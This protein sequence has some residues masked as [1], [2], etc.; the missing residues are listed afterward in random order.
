MRC[1]ASKGSH[2]SETND[3]P[4]TSA[5]GGVT[6]YQAA[7]RA[8][9]PDFSFRRQWAA[10]YADGRRTYSRRPD[11]L[12]RRLLSKLKSSRTCTRGLARSEVTSRESKPP[13]E[14]CVMRLRDAFGYAVVLGFIG[15]ATVPLGSAA[16]AA[17]SWLTGAGMPTAALGADGD[18]YL[19]IDTGRIFRKAA[20]TWQNVGLLRAGALGRGPGWYSGSGS[21]AATFGDEG[22]M[23]LDI[24]IGRAFKKT[25]GTWLFMAD[26]KGPQGPQG[27][28]GAPGP[29]G[30][31][32]PAGPA[33]AVS[34][35][36]ADSTI[37]TSVST[38]IGELRVPRTATYSVHAKAQLFYTGPEFSAARVECQLFVPGQ[39]VD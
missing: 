9:V 4:S 28:P 24:A 15:A 18:N 38:V 8:E 10:T 31:Q 33:P 20:G 3:R 29:P 17:D 23:Y 25:S 39:I 19:D 14:I 6:L 26:L 36:P 5:S 2:S 30:V 16:Q 11:I 27:L 22:D 1:A 37:P 13:K 21:P 12:F 32:G 34:I 7:L 35:T